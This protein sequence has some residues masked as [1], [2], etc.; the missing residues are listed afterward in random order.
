MSEGFDADWL[1]LRAPFDAA[2][3]STAIADALIATL[4]AR[5]KL[6]DLGAGTAALFR[7]LAPRI[8]RAQA[9]TLFDADGA[10]LDEAFDAIADWAED[11]GWPVTTPGRAMLVHTP[12]GAWRVEAV[13]GDLAAVSALPLAGHDA[14][15][16]TA[17]CDLVSA[18]WAEAIAARLRTPFYAALMVDG[19]SD[20][21]PRHP[22]DALVARAFRRDQARDKGFGPAL[23]HRAPAVLAE[24]FAGAG[25]QVRTAPSDWRIGPTAIPML[26]AIVRGDAD[27]AAR[28]LPTR[29]WDID[30][31]RA[32]RLHHAARRR[33]R[34]RLGHRDLLAI[35]R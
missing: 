16:N 33:T 34:L 3:R 2:A 35:P 11:Q 6:L 27:A 9:W 30:E 19:R 31:W 26:A 14:V 15:V 4:P 20:W 21:R 10:L 12:R 24:T 29:A 17:L 28:A 32:A 18:R 5:P 1:D 25:F 13:V 8:G 23:G 22:H 7:W